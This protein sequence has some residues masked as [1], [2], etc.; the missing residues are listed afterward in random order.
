VT[1]EKHRWDH[2]TAADLLNAGSIEELDELAAR[3]TEFLT[4]A[5]VADRLN[6]GRPTVYKLVATG[7]LPAVRLG[8]GSNPPIRIPEAELDRYVARSTIGG[9]VAERATQLVESR[10][11]D[12]DDAN[13]YAAALKDLDYEGEIFVDRTAK[14]LTELVEDAHQAAGHRTVGTH[15]RTGSDIVDVEKIINEEL[16][17]LTI[18]WPVGVQR[19]GVRGVGREALRILHDKGLTEYDEAD[20]R[21]AVKQAIREAINPKRELQ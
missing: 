20:Y 10:G 6:C 14:A 2:L 17:R 8:N 15:Q 18:P 11:Q 19:L 5:Q 4:V 1:T 9:D 3:R 12:P 21:K 7:Q 13:A 16:D